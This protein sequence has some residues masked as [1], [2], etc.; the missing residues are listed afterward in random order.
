MIAEEFIL[1]HGPALLVAIPLFAAFATPFIS[2]LNEKVRNA[3]V[4]LALLLNIYVL[5]IVG[6]NVY[7]H[8]IQLYVYGASNPGLA[9]PSGYVIP[10]RII[11]ELDAL[12]VFMAAITMLLSFIGALYSI[13]FL[14]EHDGLDKY[15]TLLL[16]MTASMLGMELTGDMFNLFVFLEILSIAS[17]ALV[18]FRSERGES[19]EA[20]FKY[21]MM[22]SLGAMFVLF[23]IGVLYGQ[24]D[25]LNMAVLSKRIEYNLL[26]KIA[27]ALLV[28]A[29]GMKAGGAPM[30]MATPDAYGEAPASISIML[31]GGSQASLYALFRVVF[32]IYGGMLDVT[33]VGWI[34]IAL[35][36]ISILIGVSMALLQTDFKRLIGYSAIA[37]IG[38][39]MLG[40]GVALAVLNDGATYGTKALEGGIFH[41]LNDALDIGL[42]FLVAGAVYYTTGKR[43]L[44]AVGGLARN[45]KYTAFFFIIG[46]AAVSGLPPMNGF[47]SKLLIY[48]SVYQ[49]NPVLSIIGI[50]ASILMLAVFAKVFQSAFLGPTLPEHKDVGE[51]PAPMLLGMALITLLIIFIGLF[52]RFVLEHF[53]SPAAQALLNRMAYLG[54]VGG[55]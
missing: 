26:D 14:K 52:P 9:L 27:L 32:T 41:I 44:N 43:S 45:M 53:V 35:A 13:S 49:L 11:F 20:A 48:E 6:R 51:V 29:F 5:F 38:Y 25:A 2:R 28:A 31:V 23:S 36:I 7:H 33:S 47:A 19:A 16:L 22:S 1:K 8:G 15:Y 54:A 4:L 24:Y 34:I 3:W 50:M 30:H 40:V 46:M 10:V 17:C 39:M 18:A 37:E 55:A 42:L 21:M 12:S